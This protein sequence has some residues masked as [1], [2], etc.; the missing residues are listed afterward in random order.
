MT[1]I[2]LPTGLTSLG[3]G[4][5]ADCTAMTSIVLPDTLTSIGAAPPFKDEPPAAEAGVRAARPNAGAVAP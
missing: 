2:K 5:F 1:S 3:S 4:A